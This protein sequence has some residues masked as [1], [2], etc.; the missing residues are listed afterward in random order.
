MPTYV[1]ICTRCGNHS[2]R[3]R[4]VAQRD[5]LTTCALCGAECERN[6]YPGANINTGFGRSKPQV[7][8]SSAQGA[9][10]QTK[11][12]LGHVSIGS[13]SY[14]STTGVVLEDTEAEGGDTLVSAPYDM[15]IQLKNVRTRN[16]KTV[17]KRN[18]TRW[19]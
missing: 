14:S 12:T 16:L 6:A 10:S 17:V 2:E 11:P 15:P 9:N 8:A 13:M 1:Y 7:E 5:V 18:R 19:R 4:P 3:G